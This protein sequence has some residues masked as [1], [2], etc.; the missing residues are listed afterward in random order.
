[1]SLF[2][3]PGT[4]KVGLKILVIGKTGV[5]KSTFGLSAP[6]SAILDSEAGISLYEDQPEGKNIQLVANTQSYVD[7]EESLDE[8]IEEHKDL[9]VESVVV[10]SESKFY[11]DITQAIMTVEERKAVQNSKD[12]LDSQLSIR[13]YGKINQLAERLQNFKLDA[14]GAGIH[15][16]S[17]A[18]ENDIKKFDKKNSTYEIVGSKPNMKKD[19]E[20]DYDIV[21]KLYKEGKGD[22]A[23]FFAEVI[24]DRSKTFK[25]GSI[26]ENPSFDMWKKRV[27]KMK[28]AKTLDTNFT[29]DS[30]TSQDSYE[31]EVVEEGKDVKVKVADTVK[32]LKE[33]GRED[34]RKE[35]GEAIKNDLGVKSLSKMT[36]AQGKE[37]LELLKKYK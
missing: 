3:K 1:M 24:K 19:A 29:A 27:D 7:L 30:K 16:I 34:E 6:K 22:K 12:P 15:V 28:D 37:V 20:Y 26:V 31:E 10:D 8:I 9:G 5:G 33:E 32:R 36:A 25:T 14:S 23:K 18:Q 4:K 11:N 2:R 13:S 17:I 21:L 35:L